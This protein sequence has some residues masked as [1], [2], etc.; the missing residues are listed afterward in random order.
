[1]T[2][3]LVLQ[4]MN[5]WVTDTKH[6]VTIYRNAFYENVIDFFFISNNINFN[7]TSIDVFSI[8]IKHRVIHPALINSIQFGVDEESCLSLPNW[9][10]WIYWLSEVKWFMRR[11]SER[12]LIGLTLPVHHPIRESTKIHSS[13]NYLSQIDTL[14]SLCTNKIK[15]DCISIKFLSAINMC[16]VN[17]SLMWDW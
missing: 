10:N 17:N 7:S 3:F 14:L 15:I 8:V 9:G 1:M 12:N 5:E 4:W 2:A 13:S 6:L 16:S 11:T